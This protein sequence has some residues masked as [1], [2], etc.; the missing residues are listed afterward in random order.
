[1]NQKKTKHF[2][3]IGAAAITAFLTSCATESTVQ[4]NSEDFFKPYKESS[5]QE[6]IGFADGRAYEVVTLIPF[7]PWNIPKTVIR[8]CPLYDMSPEQVEVLKSR[9]RI[10]KT[11][12]PKPTN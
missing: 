1:M 5:K 4:V 12:N 2:L 7:A 9:I 6:F 11:P 3:T 10:P 8:S